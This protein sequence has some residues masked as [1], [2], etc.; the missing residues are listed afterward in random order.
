MS[1]F[2]SQPPSN[3][4]YRGDWLTVHSQPFLLVFE[5]RRFV[6]AI[7]LQNWSRS[8]KGTEVRRLPYQAM[9]G[10]A[11]SDLPVACITGSLNL[12]DSIF[13]KGSSEPILEAKA[14]RQ[15][16]VLR[17]ARAQ[18]LGATELYG[19]SAGLASDIS[20]QKQDCVYNCSVLYYPLGIRLWKKYANSNNLTKLC[21][22]YARSSRSFATGPDCNAS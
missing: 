8:A 12:Q 14:A 6:S 13:D 4:G 3:C 17:S 20:P 19:I 2:E 16:R 10:M 11:I 22:K 21:T 7:Q 9:A 18:A 5:S 15:P 1:A